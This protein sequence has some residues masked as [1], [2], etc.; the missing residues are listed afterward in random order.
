M[1]L[2]YNFLAK[3]ANVAY[4][5]SLLMRFAKQSGLKY[6]AI[7]IGSNY[8]FFV[9][10]N[11]EQHRAFADFSA[12]IPLSLYFIFQH[13]EVV[14]DMPKGDEDSN[15]LDCAFCVD[16]INAIKDMN[17]PQF[18][19]IFKLDWNLVYKN[20]KISDKIALQSALH[21]LACDLE[22]GLIC[23]LKT[24]RGIF[25][26]SLNNNDF[27]FIIANDLANI[28][29]FSKASSEELDALASFEKPSINLAL[30]QIFVSE[31]GFLRALFVLPFDLVLEILVS[32]LKNQPFLYAKASQKEP[33]FSYNAQNNGCEIVVGK[34][35][36]FIQKKY[37]FIE[38]SVDNA[39][40]ESSLDNASI[41][42][43]A[44]TFCK[45]H[46]GENIF[47]ISPN[48]PTLLGNFTKNNFKHIA[49]IHFDSNPKNIINAIRARKN[50][51]KLLENY[52][53]QFKLDSIYA[54]DS[55]PKFS[56]NILDILRVASVVL[57]GAFNNDEILDSALLYLREIGPKIDFRNM[58]IE[59][60]IY[61]DAARC[62]HS[63]MSFRLAGIDK[64][65]I[66]F[67]IIESMVDYLLLLARDL[68]NLDSNN[69]NK[70]IGIAGEFFA[71]KIFF[72]V[73]SKKFPPDLELCISPF[74]DFK[75]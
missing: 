72:D 34:K 70:K 74:L 14:L 28:S 47:Y 25:D 69:A 48:R 45:Q 20:Q 38:S 29:I 30:K 49:K 24:S 13:V 40:E 8:S 62:I 50:G 53:K 4:F 16:E 19:D 17:A 43:T 37:L 56:E 59:N 67:G 22:N 71:N 75:Y 52:S 44:L 33:I 57:D 46:L 42:K 23:T 63:I 31:L 12:K 21:N 58:Q 41:K 26:L 10:G 32:L 18:C 7:N 65:T 1:I 60:E 68:S 5:E 51:D 35:G 9:S 73:F 6:Y 15:A 39:S 3:N 66:S 2:K 64:E 11:E 27:D 54:L 36:F 61:F 55:A